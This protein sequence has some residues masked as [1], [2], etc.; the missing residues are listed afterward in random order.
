[1]TGDLISN[2]PFADETGLTRSASLFKAARQLCMLNGINPVVFLWAMLQRKKI[3]WHSSH[4]QR[5]AFG[6]IL[7]LLC[8]IRLLYTDE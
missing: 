1:M 2:N 8:C 7:I 4:W 6:S 3:R 5:V